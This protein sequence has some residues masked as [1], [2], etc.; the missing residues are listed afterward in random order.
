MKCLFSNH[1][2]AKSNIVKA[3]QRIDFKETYFDA[4][5]NS[6]EISVYLCLL[7]NICTA[8]QIYS[9]GLLASCDGHL[10]AGK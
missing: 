9:Q 8:V 1:W 7:V 5:L 2:R 4:I 6:G 10:T 3:I